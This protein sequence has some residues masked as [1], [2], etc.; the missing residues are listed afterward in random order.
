[1][2]DRVSHKRGWA[3]LQQTFPSWRF[4]FRDAEVKKKKKNQCTLVTRE[5]T[6]G[7][8]NVFCQ[9]ATHTRGLL[10]SLKRPP[11]A[12]GGP[13]LLYKSESR[14]WPL[15]RYRLCRCVHLCIREVRNECSVPH[16]CV[17]VQSFKVVRWQLSGHWFQLG[18]SGILYIGADLQWV[19]A[20][21]PPMLMDITTE[22]L[23]GTAVESF[24]P[25]VMATITLP[26]RPITYINVGFMYKLCSAEYFTS[27]N[28]QKFLIVILS[29]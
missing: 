7:F 4:I 19:V 3:G 18:R 15:A 13:Q 24:G 8:G 28:A 20:P 21:P 11:F 12:S 14:H 17:C 26:Q 5:H 22:N 23:S 27:N 9:A 2:T 1:M 6:L 16:V 29:P 10:A 25:D